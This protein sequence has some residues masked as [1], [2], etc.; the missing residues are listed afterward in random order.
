MLSKSIT[1]QAYTYCKLLPHN[2]HLYML[3][4]RKN[5]HLTRNHLN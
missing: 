1:E 5:H 3:A 4:L 2:G